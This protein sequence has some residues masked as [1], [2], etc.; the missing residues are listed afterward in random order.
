MG[1]LRRLSLGAMLWN[2]FLSLTVIGIS[3]LSVSR[4][5]ALF[6]HPHSWWALAPATALLS[7]LSIVSWRG[8]HSR[9]GHKPVGWSHALFFLPL[10]L[11]LSCPPQMLSPEVISKRGPFGVL[12]GHALNCSKTHAPLPVFAEGQPI[13]VN[14]ENFLA[15]MEALWENT[16]SYIGRS[17][18]MLGFVYE[19]PSL[20]ATDFVLARLIMTCCAA[21]AEVAG[22]LCRSPEKCQLTPGQWV[23]ASGT[24]A[25]MPYYN[26]AMREVVEMP[27]LQVT[28]I[29]PAEKPAQEYIYP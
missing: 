29:V 23:T 3:Y 21:D 12:P 18:Q 28:E 16:D 7:L 10:L 14:D 25:K 5:L 9:H 27:Y 1:L 26:A 6:L 4:K 20:G 2:I 19:D 11:A 13:V 8:L 24:L 15:L 22:L 17:L